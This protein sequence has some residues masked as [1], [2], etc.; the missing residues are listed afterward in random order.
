MQAEI[1]SLRAM[2]QPIFNLLLR[3]RSLNMNMPFVLSWFGRQLYTYQTIIFGSLEYSVYCRL[4][5]PVDTF[6]V[7]LLISSISNLGLLFKSVRLASRHYFA[8]KSYQKMKTNN[9]PWRCVLTQYTKKQLCLILTQRPRALRLSVVEQA[10]VSS[11]GCLSGDFQ[12]VN[13]KF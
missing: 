2:F 9:W 10:V 12:T 4:L 6:I 11:L 3:K 13:Q 7:F 5:N 8:G 1:Q